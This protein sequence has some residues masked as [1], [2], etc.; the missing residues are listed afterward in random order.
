LVVVDALTVHQSVALQELPGMPRGRKSM[1]A[2]SVVPVIPGQGR[3]EPPSALDEAERDAWREIVSAMPS[4][5]F[6]L[7]CQPVL[8]RL[9]AQV[10]ISERLE[11]QLRK[12]RADGLADSERAARLAEAHRDA[13]RAVNQLS[14][15]LRLTPKSR[16]SARTSGTEVGHAVKQRP[17]DI[18]AR[19]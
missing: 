16:W 8:R 2:L 17:W 9:C 14:Q 6:G 4:N 13:A 5:W 1:N 3:P 19:G 18:R 7:E 10:V 11:E 15:S 12:V